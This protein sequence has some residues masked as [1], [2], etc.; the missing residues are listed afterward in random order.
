MMHNDKKN[1]LII[2]CKKQQSG[3]MSVRAHGGMNF[4][5][6]DVWRT[7]NDCEQR[8]SWDINQEK[9]FWDSKLGVNMYR[10]YSQTRRISVV[11]G[12]EFLLH[13][14]VYIDHEDGGTVYNPAIT[15]E[16]DPEFEKKF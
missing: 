9:I 15:P 3:F 11:S 7:I 2:E 6:I 10:L 1:D 12:R 13:S 4:P 14:M 5:I 8:K 16:S